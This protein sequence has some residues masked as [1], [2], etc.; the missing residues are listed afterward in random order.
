MTKTFLN[1][2]FLC[3][4]VFGFSKTLKV[5]ISF[6]DTLATRWKTEQKLLQQLFEEKGITPIIKICGGNPKT[7]LQQAYHLIDVDSVNVLIVIA[8]NGPEMSPVINYAHK[9]DITTIAYDRL[10]PNC[11]LDYYITF[12]NVKVGEMMAQ[13]M[14]SQQPTG[15][16]MIIS[17]PKKDNNSLLIHEGQMKVLQSS[18]DKG[19]IHLIED[20]HV[21]EWLD[22]AAFHKVVDFYQS[23]EDI[24]LDAILVANDN[25]LGGVLDALEMIDINGVLLGG[26]DAELTALERIKNGT[27]ALTIKKLTNNLS[28]VCVELTVSEKRDEHPSIK[29]A[30]KTNTN[31]GQMEVKSYVLNPTL[32]DQSNVSNYLK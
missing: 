25:M 29:G 24:K 22:M 2:L 5:G 26:N 13:G 19:D 18:I 8:N 6:D 21:N 15:N 3:F 14:L 17:G 27:Q 12:D 28:I 11:Y 4:T 32:I 1:I 16:Y 7:Q 20:S 31:N 10:I 23:N 9:L 30:K